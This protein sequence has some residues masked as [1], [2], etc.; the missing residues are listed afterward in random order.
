YCKNVLT[1]D[2]EDECTPH[3]PWWITYHTDKDESG[4][5]H[6]VLAVLLSIIGSIFLILCLFVG[7]LIIDHYCLLWK[8]RNH[9][10]TDFDLDLETNCN[11]DDH[12]QL[13]LRMQLLGDGQ[14]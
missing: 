11:D 1:P 12:R 9:V 6:I 2:P 3:L 13:Q 14:L 10:D 5:S 7:S 4:K 8:Y